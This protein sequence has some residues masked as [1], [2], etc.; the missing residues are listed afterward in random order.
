[1]IDGLKRGKYLVSVY[2]TVPV[3]KQMTAILTE[4]DRARTAPAPLMP[5]YLQNFLNIVNWCIHSSWSLSWYV[6]QKVQSVPALYPSV[7]SSLPECVCLF[8]LFYGRQLRWLVWRKR[9]YRN[10]IFYAVLKTVLRIRIRSRRISMFLGLL[11]PDPLVRD[12]DLA[13]EPDP[14]IIKQK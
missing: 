14:S 3:R 12:P 1:M 6:R 11:G 10:V 7:D 13:P 9:N 8:L 4:K 5:P 2:G